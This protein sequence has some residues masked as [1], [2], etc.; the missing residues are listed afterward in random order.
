MHCDGAGD[1]VRLRLE[2]GQDYHFT[3]MAKNVG[4]QDELHIST[5]N[6][7]RQ[8]LLVENSALGAT[9]SIIGED[10]LKVCSKVRL[11]DKG[12]AW[13]CDADVEAGIVKVSANGLSAEL[14]VSC[15]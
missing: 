12:C 3:L 15:Y 13:T 4:A 2:E 10:A 14:A 7:D 5:I 6:R 11:M 9:L 1:F 8:V